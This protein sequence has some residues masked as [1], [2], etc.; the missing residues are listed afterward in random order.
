M[1]IIVPFVLTVVLF[2]IPTAHAQDATGYWG[3]QGDVARVNVP[4]SVV[5]KINALPERPDISG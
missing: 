3:I 1:R 4:K 5:E 2:V